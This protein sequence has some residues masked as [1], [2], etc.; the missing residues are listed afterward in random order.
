LRGARMEPPEVDIHHFAPA[1]NNSIVDNSSSCR[2]FCLDRTFRLRPPHVDEGLAV[3][4]HFS[5]CDEN[6]ESSDSAA[7]AIA[8]LMI[9]A[10]ERT[11]PLN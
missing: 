9:W 1:R 8:N 6:V 3:D 7:D 11:A 4:Y 2:V 10:I 5:C